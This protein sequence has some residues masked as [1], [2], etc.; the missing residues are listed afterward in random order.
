MQPE[1]KNF[2][3][4]EAWGISL[5][6]LESINPATLEAYNKQQSLDDI[7]EGIRRFHDY[8]VRI[9]GMFV[10]GSDSD[11]VQ[12]IRDTVDFALKMRIDSV[13]FLMLTPLPGTPLFKQL[14]SEGRLIT[15]E[16]D[17]YD[18]H[19]AVFQP[20]LMS[21]EQLQEESFKAFKRF[22]SMSHIFQNTML[23]GWGSSLYRGVGWWLVK[24]FEKQN[25]WY[26]QILER[27]QNKSS[28]S[29]PLIY[30]RIPINQEGKLKG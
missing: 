9:H 24:R 17:L 19:H 12:T 2:R 8:G 3:A 26:D 1:T 4:D 18:G 27:L 29:V 30:R 16:W 10:F 22:Y 7:E 5:I 14:E 15:K 25:R 13:Q 11:T 23:T 6:G 21:P 20:A 28:R